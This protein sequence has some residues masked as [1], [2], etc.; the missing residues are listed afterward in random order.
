M[1]VVVYPA[2]ESGCGH[3]RIRFVSEELARQGHDVTISHGEEGPIK[4]RALVDERG[5]VQGAMEHEADVVVFQRPMKRVLVDCIPHL[6]A[7]GTAVV[8]EVDDDF[9]CIPASNP[10]FM[11]AHPKRDRNRNWHHLLRAVKLADL[12]TVSTLALAR[13]YGEKS[14]VLPNYVPERYLK[15]AAAAP[16]NEIPTVGWTGTPS[17]HADDL[18][19]MGSIS[20]VIES[21]GARFKAIG[22]E[23]TLDALQVEGD[24]IP[25]C[26]L[27]GSYPFEVARLDIG[28]VPL[29]LNAF[30]QGKSWLKGL[31]YAA[32][33]VPFIASPTEQY[34]ALDAGIIAK[35]PKDWRKH[36]RHLIEHDW[37]RAEERERG[38]EAATGLT[39]ESN[40]WRWLEVWQE[41]STRLL[42]RTARVVSSWT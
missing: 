40:A 30:N 13:R 35:K 36:L 9:T 2:D 19:V 41:A 10:A 17:T 11:H 31:E 15:I 23:A 5:A 38:L 1:K 27:T 22:D 6:Q 3:Y 29:Q 33:G 20:Q 16:K 42:D 32:L 14:V 12:V 26:D 7:Q 8:V 39:I 4:I 28:L 24:V 18:A 21:T 25:W 34:R 37:L